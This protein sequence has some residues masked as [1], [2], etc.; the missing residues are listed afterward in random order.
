[1]DLNQASRWRSLLGKAGAF[2]CFFLLFALLDGIIAKFREPYN[3]IN[4]LAGMNVPV[5]GNLGERVR[6]LE[7]LAYTSSSQQISLVFA[8][9]RKGYFLGG[10]M[11]R[12]EIRVGDRVSPG[13]YT[14]TVAV[15]GI[16]L[17][18]P[19]PPFLIV[20]YPDAY[21]LQQS[22]KSF[23][24]RE[25]GVSPWGAAAACLPFILLTFGLVFLLSRKIEGVMA[26]QGQAEVYRVVRQDGRY[27]VKFGLGTAHGIYP[28]GHL[29]VYDEGGQFIGTAEVQE[30][31]ATDSLA[32]ITSDREIKPGSIVSRERL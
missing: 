8:E 32:T 24:E 15:K 10:N 13:Q 14:V 22:S 27:L 23:I 29:V 16:L 11:W 9:F 31:S 5:D 12:G 4:V 19:L 28:G 7:D 18:R 3:V 25:T 2:F 26:E 20:V 17:T 30:A 1:M 21:S 6:G